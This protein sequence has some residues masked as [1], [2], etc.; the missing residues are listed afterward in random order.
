MSESR[1]TVDGVSSSN[2][3]VTSGVPQGSIWGPLMSNVFMNSISNVH[4]ARSI[5]CKLILYMD[6]SLLFKPVDSNS[7]LSSFQSDIN[8][9]ISWILTNSLNPNHAKSQ[10]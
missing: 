10:I 4:V 8:N 7:D 1:P 2:A 5:D 3:P 9:I 6:D